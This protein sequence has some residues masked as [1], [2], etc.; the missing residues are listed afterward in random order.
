MQKT[1]IPPELRERFE[2]ILYQ[3]D[4]GNMSMVELLFAACK[5]DRSDWVSIKVSGYPKEDAEYNVCYL[6]PNA[7]WHV[8]TVGYSTSFKR[9]D[10][11]HKDITHYQPLPQPPNQK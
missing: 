2:K 7:K 4:I 8:F 1:N 6:M 11:R 3:Y 9:F 5:M 10:F